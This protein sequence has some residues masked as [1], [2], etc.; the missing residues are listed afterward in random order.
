[1]L[2]GSGV[3]RLGWGSSWGSEDQ[4]LRAGGREGREGTG[5]RER[6]RPT[7]HWAGPRRAGSGGGAGAGLEVAAELRSL[8]TQLAM[9]RRDRNRG[10]GQRG[11]GGPHDRRPG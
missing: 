4:G 3:W 7:H 11:G 9:G 10:T 5:A 2:L 6:E 8:P 1:M